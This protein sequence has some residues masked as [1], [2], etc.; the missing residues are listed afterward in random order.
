MHLTEYQMQRQHIARGPRAQIQ[1]STVVT[2]KMLAYDLG[3]DNHLIRVLLRKSP[4]PHAKGQHWV[5]DARDG[6]RVRKYLLK[7]RANGRAHS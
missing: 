6:E 3:I 4:F 7:V 5:F 1:K 2:A